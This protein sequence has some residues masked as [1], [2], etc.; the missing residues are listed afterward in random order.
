MIEILKDNK[1]N[2][3]GMTKKE[4]MRKNIY[5]PLGQRLGYYD[6]KYTF[7]IYSNLIGEGNLLVLL[8]KI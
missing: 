5:N 3:L 7:D 4:G 8:L 1:G 6:G 2:V